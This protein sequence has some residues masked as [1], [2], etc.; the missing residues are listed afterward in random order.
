MYL[1]ERAAVGIH[2]DILDRQRRACARN[3]GGMRRSRGLA[4]ALGAV[5]LSLLGLSAS[6]S[7]VVRLGKYTQYDAGEY[8]I[9]SSRGSA[10]ARRIIEDLAMFRATLERMLGRRATRNTTPTAIIVTSAADWEKWFKPRQGVAG[11]FRASSFSN[12]MALD[13]DASLDETLTVVFHEFTH[14]FLATR[15]AGEYPPWFHEGLAELMGYTRFDKGKAILRIPL[16]RL[17]DARASDWIPFDR[18][19]RVDQS[20]PEYQSHKL[21][22]AFYAQSWLTVHYG[23][24]ENPEFG[25]Q[26]FQYLQ[27]LNLLVPQAEA[28]RKAFGEDLSIIDRKL[29]DYS[30]SARMSSGAISFGE[31]P[32]VEIAAG[33][34]LDDVSTWATVANL[35][36][37]AYQD[38]ARVRPLIDALVESDPNKARP[39]IFEA[40]LAQRADDNSAFDAAVTR[41]ESGLG[42]NDWQ[43]RRDLG[44]V[45]IL[46]CVAADRMPS[47]D[48][49]SR[50]SDAARAMKWFAEA[51]TQNKQDVQA[52]WGFGAAAVYLDKNLDLAEQTLTTAYQRA[53]TN[54]EIAVS[55]ANLKGRQQ[56]ADGML[57]YLKDAARYAN[58]LRT[59]RWAT[60][61][62]IETEK[63][64]EERNAVDAE[65]QRRHEEF[66]K[67][68]AKKK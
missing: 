65:N 43:Q 4:T 27:E 1:D 51:V 40:R 66:E 30:R 9:V 50:I 26:M 8:I 67:Q 3:V 21:M 56:D 12:H 15:F 10:Q 25:R 7:P 22:P 62:L 45:L 41:A 44:M 17:R 33:Q 39:A 32:P 42:A 53:P 58:D 59:K 2:V 28:A 57:P 29:R 6:A 5:A 35:L 64:I 38:A 19:I 16:D 23:M 48:G 14:Y 61:T 63:Y 55:L 18:L 46:N 20:D 37:D 34:P 68:K 13:G 60:E 52:L 47:R 11:Y 24:V 54:A 36:L 31:I 49:E